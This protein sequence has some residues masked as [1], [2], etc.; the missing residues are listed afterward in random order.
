[1]ELKDKLHLDVL[2][3]GEKGKYNQRLSNHYVLS[4]PELLELKKKWAA[5]AWD[6]GRNDYEQDF[7]YMER[8]I[9]R[10]PN[11]PDK[12]QYLDNLNL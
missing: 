1:M 5:E 10:N 3:Y 6:G 7:N 12:Q 11:H 2:I 4:T 8:G 9:K